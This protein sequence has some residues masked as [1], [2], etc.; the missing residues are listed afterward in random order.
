[1]NRIAT[2]SLRLQQQN[3]CANWKVLAEFKP[4]PRTVLLSLA[5][6]KLMYTLYSIYRRESVK[7]SYY[8]CQS[9]QIGS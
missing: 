4:T 8:Y 3:Q 5:Y 7:N 1:M 6:I 9:D 2:V